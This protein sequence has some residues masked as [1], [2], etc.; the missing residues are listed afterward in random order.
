VFALKKLYEKSRLGFALAL[1]GVYCVAMSAGDLLSVAL[2]LEKS[3]TLA[4]AAALSA[5]LLV[6]LKKN[7]LFSAY[8]FCPARVSAR[9]ML[10]Y[11]PAIVMLSANFWLGGSVRG[12]LAETVLYILSMLFVGFL[13][14][15]IFRGFLFEALREKDLKSAVLVSSLTFG[16]GHI[17][18]L[19]NGSGA[20]LLPSLLQVLY[21]T[22]AGFMFVMIYHRSGSLLFCIAAH[23]LFNAFSAFSAD[24]PFMEW[25]IASALL[26]TAL[27]GGYGAYLALAFSRT[28]V[29]R[30]KDR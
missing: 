9:K 26:L 5:V 27:T 13:E 11:L 23:G 30:G 19:F 15:L 2:G 28:D 20:E 14:E 10:Y 29:G 6:F 18:N 17:I 21:A 24:C 4:V 25:Q 1:I 16:M 12:P 7:G 22:A 8:G 3:V